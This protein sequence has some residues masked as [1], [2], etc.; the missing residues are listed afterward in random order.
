M[1]LNTTSENRKL[2]RKIRPALPALIAVLLAFSV[3]GNGFAENRSLRPII[4]VKHLLDIPKNELALLDT[5]SSWKYFIGHIPGAR[6][7]DNWQ[8]F[9]VKVNDAPGIL[10]D[11]KNFL[12]EKLRQLGIDHSKSIVIYGDAVDKW[13]TDGRF[14]WMFKYLGFKNVAILEGGID[15]WKKDTMPLEGG[16]PDDTS[17]SALAPEEIKFDDSVL[18]D[19]TWIKRRL[20]SK[21]LAIID[22]RER[23][24][25]DGETPYGSP[26]GGHIPGAVHLDWRDFFTDKGTLKSEAQLKTI[27]NQSGIRPEQE[28]VVYCTGG[29]RSGMSFLVLQ[30]LGYKV[31]NYDGSWWDWSR[32]PSLP[33]EN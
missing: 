15:L 27:L 14:Y 10:N 30:Y 23:S 8:D 21:S 32:N 11:D 3:A 12:A 18:A 16:T 17:P 4:N 6:R 31:R 13:R 29:V 1:R 20:G 19:Q 7:I 26:R 28:A 24:E 25:Y 2:S 33:A 22:T 5:R 9:T